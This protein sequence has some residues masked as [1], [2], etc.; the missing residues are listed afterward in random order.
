[1]LRQDH[2]TDDYKLVA[3]ADMLHNF[4]EEIALPLSCFRRGSRTGALS[5]GARQATIRLGIVRIPEG[6]RHLWSTELHF[7]RRS[8]LTPEISLLPKIV[9]ECNVFISL[10]IASSEKQIPPICW[11]TSIVRSDGWSCC[12]RV[13]CAQ[14]QARYPGLRYA[15]NVM[16]IKANKILPTRYKWL[17]A[18]PF[19]A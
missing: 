3:L 7:D 17:M 14:G 9:P 19:T 10:R 15:P 5:T 16:K 12:S 4:E 6:G 1:M 2:V 13:S 11:E 18:M 8:T